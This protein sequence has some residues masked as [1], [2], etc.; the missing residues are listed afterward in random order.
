[1]LDNRA[2]WIARLNAGVN[3]IYS[4]PGSLSS[5]TMRQE[6]LWS[7]LI[8]LGA[9]LYPPTSIKAGRKGFDPRQMADMGIL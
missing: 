7:S 8:A 9:S 4:V 6:G 2:A 3:A 1:M 5:T